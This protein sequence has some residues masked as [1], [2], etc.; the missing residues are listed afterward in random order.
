MKHK[1]L[2]IGI[3][4]HGVIDHNPNYFADFCREAIK[5]GHQIHIITGGPK[6]KVAQQ[7]QADNILYSH[8]FAIVDFYIPK[9]AVSEF[10]EGHCRIDDDLW[11]RAKGIYCSEQGI[12]IHIDDS[13]EYNKYFSTPYCLYNN[14]E[15]YCT[16]NNKQISF[17]YP[18]SQ[19]LDTIEKKFI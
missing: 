5:R 2:K 14:L 6:T 9:N 1:K 13:T 10:S 19:A 3:D 17:T 16:I 8:I 11:N 15:H 7:L 4:Y 12:D 18:V